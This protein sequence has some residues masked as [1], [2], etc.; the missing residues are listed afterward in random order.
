MGT[1]NK[2]C[3]RDPLYWF[4]S[5]WVYRQHGSAICLS[6][7]TTRKAPTDPA[8]CFQN[9][10][11]MVLPH[12]CHSLIACILLNSELSSGARSISSAW[13]Q[14]QIVFVTLHCTSAFYAISGPF[15]EINLFKL[16]AQVRPWV[17]NKLKE[18]MHGRSSC[19]SAIVFVLRNTVPIPTR[20]IHT[21]ARSSTFIHENGV[22]QIA[23]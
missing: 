16:W 10:W 12:W 13:K 23:A 11:V 21:N 22:E 1:L 20:H 18:E 6:L 2:M 14:G 9:Q 19:F 3:A 4:F 17:M 5:P 7:I 8:R 15:I